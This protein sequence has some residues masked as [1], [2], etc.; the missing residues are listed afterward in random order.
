MRCYKCNSVLSDEDY[1]LKCGADV[2]V[3][4]IVVKASNSY[5]NQGLEKARVRDLT[6]AVTALKTSLSLN[7]KNIKARNLLGLVY[8]E[9]GELAMALSEWVISLNLKQ[10]RNV[11][12][13]YIR[14]VKSN[15]NKL[16]LI[17]QAAKRYNIA[18]AKAKEGGDDVALIQL[19]KVA[20]TYPKFIRANL[21]L[22]LIYMKRN[23]DERALK[24]LHRV[25]KIDR[26]NTLALKYI[27]EINGASQ[28]QP[29]DGNEEYYRNSKRKPL[30]GNDVIL[31]RNSY[32]E[33]S[34]GVFTVVYILLG[35]VIGAALI[36]FLIV[37]AKLQSSQHENN[38]TIKKYSEQL[39][40]YSVEI[41]TL[42]KQ[43]EELTSQL[44]AANKELE[45]YKGDSG[46]TALY[47]K[48]VEA[49]SEY[50][51]NDVDKAALALADID[52]T[53]LPTQTAKDLYTTLEDKCNGGARTFY[54]AGLNAYNQ[55]NYVDAA[56]YLEKAYELDNKSVETPYYLA[57]SSFELNDL[58][59]A[60]KYVD[61]VNS[62]FGDTTF[63]KQLKEYVDSRTEE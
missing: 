13:V 37:P 51:A 26:N 47:A 22:A 32:K 8:Y 59:N 36:W 7:K 23:E 21:L 14:K 38:D 34:S 60:Q 10:D 2:S 1:C 48:L 15:P 6:G 50:L 39:S 44:D 19:K 33:P 30:S 25:L 20:A 24:V 58:E 16:E 28:T 63:A 27:D 54:M 42:E 17:N 55:K 46:E 9:M 5:Y 62:K 11:A 49:V 52:V 18:L 45:Q 61:V 3:Y 43:N 4:K 41:T 29:A 35:V 56:K 40:G 57:M 31:P 53:Q 12:E